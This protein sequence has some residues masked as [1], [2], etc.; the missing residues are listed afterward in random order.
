MVFILISFGPGIIEPGWK[1]SGPNCLLENL[2]NVICRVLSKIKAISTTYQHLGRHTNL[3]YVILSQFKD[4]KLKH[5]CRHK[6]EKN[7]RQPVDCFL[8]VILHLLHDVLAVSWEGKM[9]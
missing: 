5:F 1:W 3:L 2:K 9:R 6:G 4:R 7:G 8:D